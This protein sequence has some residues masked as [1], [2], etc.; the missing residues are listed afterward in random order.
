MGQTDKLSFEISSGLAALRQ[1]LR[2]HNLSSGELAGITG[3]EERKIAAMALSDEKPDFNRRAALE[4][5]AVGLG[6]REG[7]GFGRGNVLSLIQNYAL[8][9]SDNPLRVEL[10]Q[11]SPA[12]QPIHTE[13]FSR[14]VRHRTLRASLLVFENELGPTEFRKVLGGQRSELLIEANKKG[15]LLPGQITRLARVFHLPHDD[16]AV[17]VD[18]INAK[19][20]E[21]R[22][23]KARKNESLRSPL[24]VPPVGVDDITTASISKHAPDKALKSAESER[25]PDSSSPAHNPTKSFYRHDPGKLST[26]D[27]RRLIALI[28]RF[29]QAHGSMNKLQDA[30]GAPLTVQRTFNLLKGVRS[31][32]D[33][34]IQALAGAPGLDVETAFERATQRIRAIEKDQKNILEIT[35][36]ALKDRGYRIDGSVEPSVLE[37]KAK[38]DNPANKNFVQTARR[39]MD[40]LSLDTTEL[41]RRSGMDL[42][43]LRGIFNYAR[44]LAVSDRILI[45]KNIVPQKNGSRRLTLEEYAELI[46]P[47]QKYSVEEIVDAFDWQRITKGQTR[48][49]YQKECS[50]E[51]MHNM[52]VDKV[53]RPHRTELDKE[54][55]RLGYDGLNVF[56]ESMK[57]LKQEQLERQQREAEIS[58][59]DRYDVPTL[60]HAF[61]WM[62]RS[63]NLLVK[64]YAEDAAAAGTYAHMLNF[65]KK[66]TVSPDRNGLDLEAR[67]LGYDG[68]NAL[69]EAV[70]SKEK[71]ISEGAEPD[72]SAPPQRIKPKV[73]RQ[74]KPDPAILPAE[75]QEVLL[76]ATRIV[77][78]YYKWTHRDLAE[79][80]NHPS[81]HLAHVDKVLAKQMPFREWDVNALAKALKLADVEN[82]EAFHAVIDHARMLVPNMPP[83]ED[84]I[85]AFR[86]V[87]KHRHREY[88]AFS[89]KAGYDHFEA[90][91]KGSQPDAS[92]EQLNHAA[93]TLSFRDLQNMI[94]EAR[95]M[96]PEFD[97]LAM[98]Q[99]NRSPLLN[100]VAVQQRRNSVNGLL[101]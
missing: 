6:D 12:T 25:H 82:V 28:R 42:A 94:G 63:Q 71:S 47:L 24:T 92:Y 75:K 34:D 51:H 77:L 81:F 46:E 14:I 66:P 35:D 86:I 59:L 26:E 61:D 93:Q 101:R 87:L 98:N 83:L 56:V 9:T 85:V 4:A 18:A 68:L 15:A 62:R 20:T 79:K 67:R 29:L 16:I 31:P 11:P 48:K 13:D 43:V 80:A 5:I 95:Q 74:V 27:G 17:A 45:T 37:V 88:T 54:A 100:T 78:Q 39:V 21:L 73:P 60:R 64:E 23:R 53:K 57:S 90:F 72:S 8:A 38:I 2:S 3:V 97:A 52:L 30:V 96:E 76:H 7:W 69:V 50:Y 36:S 70:K 1:Y 91:M 49:E 33:T 41:S 58:Q 84:A 99:K 65:L 32:R 40:M 44:P 19:A 55:R 22:Q 89:K 10:P